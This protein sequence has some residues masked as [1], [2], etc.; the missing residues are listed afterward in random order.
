MQNTGSM[1]GKQA[2][3]D[4]NSSVACI[5]TKKIRQWHDVVSRNLNRISAVLNK[6]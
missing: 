3:L 6:M 5:Q 4:K 1:F 2:K